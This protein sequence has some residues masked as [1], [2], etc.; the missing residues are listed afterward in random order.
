MSAG[1]RVRSVL[2]QRMVRVFALI[3]AIF[4]VDD[5]AARAASS[6][7]TSGTSKKIKKWA[8][9]HACGTAALIIRSLSF[10]LAAV[11]WVTC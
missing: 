2:D 3:Q 9:E 6:V 10:D 8:Y 1:Y 4:V 7:T 5:H 11:P